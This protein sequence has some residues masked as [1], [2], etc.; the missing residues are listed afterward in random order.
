MTSRGRRG[1]IV[2]TKLAETW[3]TSSSS[4]ATGISGDYVDKDLPVDIT[5]T[6]SVGRRERGASRRGPLDSPSFSRRSEGE[7]SSAD[8]GSEAPHSVRIV[9]DL[10]YFGPAGGVSGVDPRRNEPPRCAMTRLVIGLRGGRGR[11]CHSAVGG[12]SPALMGPLQINQPQHL[13]DNASFTFP[14]SYSPRLALS[15]RNATPPPE[16]SPP[17]CIL[18]D[19]I[20]PGKKSTTRRHIRRNP[21]IPGTAVTIKTR[22]VQQPQPSPSTRRSREILNNKPTLHPTRLPTVDPAAEN[23]SFRGGGVAP[24]ATQTPDEPARLL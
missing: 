18:S 16:A 17:F 12:H 2:K 11:L 10:F 5:Y 6:W 9:R 21:A 3:G 15:N 4:L 8:A 13:L 14:N 7:G 20:R 1:Q 22:L 24:I 19:L 23:R